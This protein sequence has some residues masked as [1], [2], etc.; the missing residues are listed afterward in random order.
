M[1]LNFSKYFKFKREIQIFICNI[2]KKVKNKIAENNIFH[3][4][5]KSPINLKKSKLFADR[6]KIFLFFGSPTPIKKFIDFL[7]PMAKKSVGVSPIIYLLTNTLIYAIY[8]SN[9]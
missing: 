2:I 8:H 3:Q 9:I 5:K 4:I 6:I 1:N 7:S